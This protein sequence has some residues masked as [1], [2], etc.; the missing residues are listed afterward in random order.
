MLFVELL[1]VLV[2]VGTAAAAA[3]GRG[4]RMA[5]APIDRNFL[6]LPDER[7]SP[8]DVAGVRFSLTV[9]GYRMSE[10]DEV[11][12]RL[13]WELSQRDAH[14]A[15]MESGWGKPGRLPGMTTP[16]LPSPDPDLPP[17]PEPITPQPTPQPDDVPP[18]PHDPEIEPP[19]RPTPGELPPR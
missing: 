11:L 13:A 3:L 18:L 9:R 14:I 8:D 2:V 15:A 4:D 16:D 19:L 7:I 6:G 17:M 5:A 1:L 10:V 12:D